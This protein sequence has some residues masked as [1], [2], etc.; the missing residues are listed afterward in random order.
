VR[1]RF[2]SLL[3]A[4]LLGAAALVGVAV[5]R[6]AAAAPAAPYS[7]RNVEV[8]GGGFVPGIVFSRAQQGLVYA[9][10]DIGGA[11]RFNAATSRW[12]PMLDWVGWSNWGWN[13]VV[14]LAADPV[15]ANRVYVAAGMYTNSWDPNNGAVLRSTDRGATWT[16]SPLPFKLG[17]NMPG[18]AMGERLAVD[19]NR[20]SVLY[21]GTPNRNGLWRSTDSGAT[22]ARVTSFPNTGDYAP[23]PNDS[24]GY[25]SATEGIVWV[26]FDESSST[27]GTASRTI[28]AGVADKANTV[29]RS[30]DAGATWAPVAGAPTGFIAHKGVLDAAGHTL[31]ITTSDTGGPYDGGK[32]DVWKYDTV[33][34]AWTQI[35]PVPSSSADDYFGYSGLTLDRQHPGTL[36][37][38]T[39]IA[40]WPDA[41]FFRS[42][43]R[44]ATWTRIWDFTSYPNRSLRYKQDIAAV[45]WLTFGS[46]PQPPETTPKLGWMNASVEIDPFNSDRLLYG[47]GATIYGS[48]DLTAWDRGGQITIKPVVAGL[49]E[50]AVLDLISPPTGAPLVSGLG[51]IGGF[52]HGDLGAVPAKMFAAPNFTTTTS[53][54][55]AETNPSVMV[56]A[57]NFTD[58]D[59]PNDSHVAFSTDG[60]SNWFQGSEPGGVNEGG[61][62]A[63]AADGSRFVW[64]PKGLP[65]VFSVGFGN[66]WTQAAGLP[67]GAVVE[68]DRVDPMRFYGHS[69]GRFYLSVD[70]GAH[71]TA[72][73]ALP[74]ATAKFKAV[75]GVRGDL[76]LAG[77]GGLWH[78][79]DSGASFTR[80]TTVASGLSVGFGRAAPG[81]T[82]PALYLAG[83][84]DGVVGVY[85]SDNAGAGWLRINDDAH[86]Y[87]NMGETITGDPRVYGRVY[88]GTN[89]RGILVAEPSGTAPPTP[90]TTPGPPS[91]PTPS[92]T[93]GT[94]PTP[95]ASP[96]PGPTPSPAPGGGCRITAV[97]NPWNTG[98]TADLTVRNTGTTPITGWTVRWTFGGNQVV[99]NFWNSTVTQT[100][101]AVAATNADHNRTI[102]AGGTASFGLQANYTGSSP[103]PGPFT[104]NGT[105]CT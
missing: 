30:T 40:W 55:Y 70:G 91:S 1:P 33:S 56:R 27:A 25:S 86:Q 100:G 74:Q 34:G 72:A 20:N 9:R 104:L 54:D 21:L 105:T 68:S 94:T 22:W 58:S 50:T 37:V 103:L 31:Y 84:V 66:S 12:V 52:R 29:Y 5:I 49:E 45:P 38:A 13:G 83:T 73:A 23:D 4:A 88:L 92:P 77:E 82:Y 46:N 80:V 47:T 99:T 26:T 6:P 43:D 39:Q 2:V 89:G 41:I 35:S 15:D 57:G 76:W 8:A 90:T 36:M 81:S 14:S 95:T 10:T 85:R 102:A 59:R 63:A 71:F 24:T 51:D 11:Y 53:L 79:V 3:S 61:T 87:G 101:T 32:G 28:Y 62:V 17:G 18:R 16:A 65:P 75:P 98:F 7:W 42:T 19:P 69:A 44:G 67:T 97:V 48:T 78:S 60:G 64:A 96:T 93:P